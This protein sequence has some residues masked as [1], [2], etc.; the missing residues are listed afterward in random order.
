MGL[1]MYLK[2][3]QYF[4]SYLETE[5]GPVGAIRLAAGMQDWPVANS[6]SLE[7]AATVAYWRKANAIH[8]WFV[9]ECGGGEDECQEMYVEREQ[10]E[11]LA[12]LCKE[13]LADQARSQALRPEEDAL[14]PVSGF[15]FGPEEKDEWYFEQLKRTVEQ[16]NEVLKKVPTS[17]DLYYQAS[18]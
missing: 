18:W 1:D 3:K 7:V 6:A 13:H 10:L 5:K 12:R 8:G 9:R 4:S 11:E 15:F 17:V 2:A 14:R 16:I